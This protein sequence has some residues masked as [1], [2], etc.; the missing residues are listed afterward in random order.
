MGHITS[1]TELITAAPELFTELGNI[2]CSD[3]DHPL[4]Q[5]IDRYGCEHERGDREGN[6]GEV[7]QAMGPCGC[8]GSDEDA[9]AIAALRK[10]AGV[11][12]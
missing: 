8:S 11:A 4:R 7:A 1:K 3:C 5:H 10:A 6:E 2:H 12:K 9:K